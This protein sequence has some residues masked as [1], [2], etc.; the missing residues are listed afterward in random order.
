MHVTALN[1]VENDA[2]V[3]LK[4]V[5]DDEETGDDEENLCSLGEYCFVATPLVPDLQNFHRIQFF[6]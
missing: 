3:A 5:E 4:D 1:D 6:H 2:A